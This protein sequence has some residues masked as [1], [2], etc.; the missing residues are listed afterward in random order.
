[1]ITVN[2]SYNQV[3]A[4]FHLLVLLTDPNLLSFLESVAKAYELS[5]KDKCH[6]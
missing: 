6:D 1:M 3:K 2:L 5:V 4:A